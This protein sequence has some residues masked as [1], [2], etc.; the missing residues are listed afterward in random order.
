MIDY[1]DAPDA[2][3]TLYV[4]GGRSFRKVYTADEV[5]DRFGVS[6]RRVHALAQARGV[7]RKLR[8]VWLFTVEEI[9]AMT[10]GPVGRP[11]IEV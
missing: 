2:N 8:G 9:E 5:A 3:G 11:R 1:Q 4:R 10:P 7:G 6:E